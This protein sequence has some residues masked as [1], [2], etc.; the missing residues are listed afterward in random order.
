MRP[1]HRTH[2]RKQREEKVTRKI[3]HLHKI[4]SNQD[5]VSESN[6]K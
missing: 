5:A 1:L 2:L 4:G 6:K 3:E